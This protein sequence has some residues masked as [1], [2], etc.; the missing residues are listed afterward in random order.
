MSGALGM[1]HRRFVVIVALA[2]SIFAHAQSLEKIGSRS[3]AKEKL[4]GAWHLVRIDAPAPDGKSVSGPQAKGMLIYTRDGH[5]A[6]NIFPTSL[7][8]KPIIARAG[9]SPNPLRAILGG[10][11]AT[12]KLMGQ[13]TGRDQDCRAQTSRLFKRT[14][15]GCC[16][17]SRRSLGE[18]P[19]C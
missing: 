18:F 13:K 1:S 17:S 10:L 19:D 4:I 6:G 7:T 2:F 16:C 14:A 11:R 12:R 15:R 8:V 5:V 9:N 3:G